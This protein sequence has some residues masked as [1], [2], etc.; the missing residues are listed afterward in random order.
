[1]SPAATTVV[2]PSAAAAVS[3]RS[4]SVRDAVYGRTIDSHSPQDTDHVRQGRA[5]G[6]RLQ[7]LGRQLQEALNVAVVVL[8]ADRVHPQVEARELRRHHRGD[9][10]VERAL[11][12]R[13]DAPALWIFQRRPLRAEAGTERGHVGGGRRGLADLTALCS[14]D[15]LAIRPS[16][17]VSLRLVDAAPTVLRPLCEIGL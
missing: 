9:H 17:S 6:G 14:P 13:L 3:W 15:W 16:W 2:M 4:M 12:D 11:E 5:I 1:V 7:R 10:R 8:L